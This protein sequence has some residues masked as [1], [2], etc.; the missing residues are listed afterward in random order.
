VRALRLGA[1]LALA[2]AL[3]CMTIDSQRDP[4]YQ[5]PAVYSG[6]HKDMAL[7]ASTRS[8]GEILFALSF[9]AVD[10]P[11]S[12]VADTVLL[13]VTI[14]KDRRREQDQAAE[15]QTGS[16]RPSPIEPIPGEDAL[17]TARRLFLTC[18]QLLHA[19]DSHLAD[20]YSVDADVEINGGSPL[21][22]SEYK[23][24]LRVGMA[25]DLAA[26]QLVEWR[27]PSFS[28]DGA[29]VRI[30][31]TRASSSE[32]SRSPLVLYVAPCAD[33]AWRI[34]AETSIGWAAR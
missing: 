9:A 24:A 21:R 25:R 33:G 22:G 14:P 3:G 8:M 2:G 4:G 31:A 32:P 23:Q 10:L 12:A 30:D 34:V 28:A 16:E 13:P 29:R 19:Q 17:A 7:L 26:G 15:T 6:V 20:C 11:F 1:A 18:A 27:E 5:G